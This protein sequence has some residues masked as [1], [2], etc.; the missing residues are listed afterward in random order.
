LAAILD[1]GLQATPLREWV[2]SWPSNRQ[3]RQ[4]I[5]EATLYVTLEPSNVRQGEVFPPMTQLIEQSGIPR[6]VIG[7]PD[8]VPEKATKGAGYLHS[9][10]II[11]RLGV[12]QEAC[13]DLIREYS[14]LANTKLQKMARRHFQQYGKVCW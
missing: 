14:K 5:S 1:A 2:V 3:L 10:G 9:I 6:V 8:P 7:C 4:D 11:V 13:E 12:E